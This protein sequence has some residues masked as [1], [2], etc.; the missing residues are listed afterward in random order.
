[1]HGQHVANGQPADSKEKFSPL[2]GK[3]SSSPRSAA[4]DS[5]SYKS[6][7]YC[8]KDGRKIE[9]GECALFQAG[10]APPFIGIL[11]KVTIDKDTTVRLKVN[12]LYRPADIKLARGV[13]IDA[14]PNEIFYSFH[15][16]DTPAA[17]LL[18]PCRV[19]FLRKGVELPSGVSSFVC[20]RVYD[21]SHK[22]LWWLT[23][24]D[25]TDEHQEE[26]DQLLNRTKL[27]MQAAIQQ[28]GARSPRALALSHSEHPQTPVGGSKGKKRERSDSGHEP[29]SNT[30]N[31]NAAAAA[32]PKRAKAD[33]SESSFVKSSTKPEEIASIIDKDGGLCSLAGVEKLVS[34]MQQDR[35]DGIRKPMEV[36]SRRIMLAGVVASTDKQE[37]RDRLVQ[38]GGL[39]VLDDWLQEAHKGKSGSDCG[40]PAEL[41]KVLDELLLTLLRALQKLPVD[42]DALKSCHVGKSVNNLKS[43]R[44]VEIQKKARKLVET[45]KKRVGAEVKQSGEKMG[46][47]QAPANDPLQPV[48]K[49]AKSSTKFASSNGPNTEA[50]A[51][52][53]GSATSKSG[54][55][56]SSKE[57]SPNNSGSNE[58]QGL[59]LKEE[60]SCASHAQNYGPAW[61]SA[62][63]TSACKEEVKTKSTRSSKVDASAAAA[64]K[65][66]GSGK[67]V[68][69]SRTNANSAERPAGS[70]KSPGDTDTPQRFLLRFPNPGKSPARA[71]GDSQVIAKVSSP[72][73]L[74]R[75]SSS[76]LG[77]GA[78]GHGKASKHHEISSDK[79]H[80]S[81]SKGGGGGGDKSAAEKTERTEARKASSEKAARE[82]NA[83]NVVDGVS[84]AR[85]VVTEEI[86]VEHDNLGATTSAA[87]PA[88][89]PEQQQ[90]PSAPEN[91]DVKDG[92]A[93]EPVKTDNLR[94]Q[95]SRTSDD[96]SADEV[97]RGAERNPV[98][99]KPAAEK[100]DTTKSDA[101]AKAGE[102]PSSEEDPLEVA[103]MV[104]KEIEE[105]YG[106]AKPRAGAD[107]DAVEES[108]QQ[109]ASEEQAASQPGAE[110]GKVSTAEPMITSDENQQEL[111]PAAAQDTPMEEALGEDDNGGGESGGGG[112]RPLFD[113]NEGFPAED[114]PPPAIASGQMFTPLPTNPLPAPPPFS[115]LSAP[116]AVMASTRT[117]I[118]P[119]SLKASK[120][121]AG[122][123]GSAATSAFRPAEKKGKAF[124][125]IDL[126]VAEGDDSG[127][128]MV[129][130]MDAAP[131]A[132]RSFLSGF[133]NT[134]SAGGAEKKVAASAALDLNQE[135]EEGG[136]LRLRPPGG[137]SSSTSTLRNFDLNDGPA[138]EDHPAA[139]GVGGG[140]HGGGEEMFFRNLT[141]KPKAS[142]SSNPVMNANGGGGELLNV[143]W[144]SSVPGAGIPGYPGVS[145]AGGATTTGRTDQQ[146][147]SYSTQQQ[148]QQQQ[149][150]FVNGGSFSTDLYR[151]AA[152]A[153]AA[154][155]GGGGGGGGV[156][157]SSALGSYQQNP[158]AAAAAA[159]A[160]A[161]YS[162][163]GFSFNSSFPFSAAAATF[164]APSPY[165]ASSSIPAPSLSTI[166]SNSGAF[167]RQPPYF[168]PGDHA[169][170]GAVD[171]SSGSAG[172]WGR[173]SLDLNTGP[174]PA[175]AA[176]AAA[177]AAAANLGDHHPDQARQNYGI[178]LLD[179]QMRVF[180]QAA[181]IK[182]K[183]P[184]TGWDVYRGYTKWR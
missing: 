25:Y 89:K 138:F 82:N 154:A 182:R 66:N 97:R 139:V 61:S 47:K 51:K 153:A 172:G 147:A 133:P 69:W 134:S 159:A 132:A 19:A 127:F 27:E 184:E 65:E 75:S 7:S 120:D 1:M 163:P 43:H 83:S 26:V 105:G 11:R 123:K 59:S 101:A 4:I 129:A 181:A 17:S 143:S 72:K 88:E 90:K 15:K 180:H 170:G 31:T 2:P 40:H 29:S 58:I 98:E 103:R 37:C 62:P 5:A 166:T 3:I 183:E 81:E 99:V 54:T 85:S 63:V 38:L 60:K 35:N 73:V 44:M 112:A 91:G 162:Y 176:A 173:R 94:R 67:S 53:V 30:T 149:H 33:D 77:E 13:P 167:G 145:S 74:D 171:A 144:F 39:A 52:S 34:L 131:A 110:S 96:V 23:D 177:A 50:P 92:G 174:D 20:R 84:T 55:T 116:I 142:S 168:M 158:Q 14:A 111:Q 79:R 80:R 45:W 108:Q 93:Q 117:F 160:A 114:S 21:T 151:A 150:P 113:L 70:E 157:S 164:V 87:C 12:W 64:Q 28:P 41:D 130:E 68:M 109:R 24:R 32:T 76:G 161:L 22:R 124:L 175:V 125:D 137:A 156:P 6:S 140:G 36:A 42:L 9:V 104:A 165:V 49:D 18:H 71:N 107:T 115:S 148:Q 135:S 100:P 126:N 57:N 178:P 121:A 141:T 152:A 119:S 136:S 56:A 122:W 106:G 8:T 95:S 48:A 179:E 146:S 118:P 16:D 86:N 102:S 46:S 78:G 169:G 10:N 128:G 155:A